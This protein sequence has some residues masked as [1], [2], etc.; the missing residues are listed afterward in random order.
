[1]PAEKSSGYRW[2]VLLAYSL[3]QAAMQILWVSFAP[4]TGEAAAFYHVSPLQIGLLSLVFMVVYLFM[5][6]PASWAIDTLGVKKGTGFGLVVMGLFGLVRGVWGENFTVVTIATIFIAVAQPFVL[7]SVTALGA[8]WFPVEERATAA[9][10]AVLSQF[11]GIVL[12]MVMSPFLYIHLG[13]PGM[14]KVYGLFAAGSAVV[15]LVL[16]KER[17]AGAAAAAPPEERVQVWKGLKHIVKQRDMLILIAVMFIGLGIFNAVT[18]WIEQLIEPRGFSI[19][20]AGTL[21][22]AMMLAGILGALVVPLL[23]DRTRKRKVWVMACLI[24]ACPGLIG[25]TYA[26]DFIPLVLSGIVFGFFL[27]GGGPVIYQYSAEICAPAPEATSQGLLLLAGQ[28]SGILFIFGMDAFRS[29]SGA[30]TPFMLLLIGLTAVNVI[31]SGLMKES[32]AARR[33]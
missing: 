7:N 32:G 18:T 1:M 19:T 23:S 4:I 21:G 8:R 29:E 33:D 20:Q 28:V 2:V 9:G 13:A 6:L 31:L 10:I 27:L 14:L 30:M 24:G 3:G 17:P 22:A 26:V 11:I 5:S 15:F 25:L 12:A 16:V